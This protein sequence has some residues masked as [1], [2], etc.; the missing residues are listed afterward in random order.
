VRRRRDL[1][2]AL[3]G[4][5]GV[6][7]GGSYGRGGALKLAENDLV[8]A[9][10]HGAQVCKGVALR[11][12]CSDLCAHSCVERAEVALVDTGPEAIGNETRQ[13]LD[14]IVHSDVGDGGKKV[15]KTL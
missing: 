12:E 15:G 5:C 2:E 3:T 4:H 11:R 8:L 6:I 10:Q 1:D 7:N 13:I 14:H 9:H